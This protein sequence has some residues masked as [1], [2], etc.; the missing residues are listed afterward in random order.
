MG[1]FAVAFA[2]AHFADVAELTDEV[3]KRDS[4]IRFEQCVK[5]LTRCEAGVILLIR[6]SV[7]GRGEKRSVLL[8][9]HPHHWI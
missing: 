3:G 1:M 9:R 7:P 2:R 5:R 8:P 6:R 4:A